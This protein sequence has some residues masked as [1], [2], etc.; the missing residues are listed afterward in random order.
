MGKKKIRMNYPATPRIPPKNTE[1]EGPMV[2][3]YAVAEWCPTPDGTGPA[4]AVAVVF[5]IAGFGDVVLRLKT[6]RAVNAMIAALIH[7]RDEVFKGA[8]G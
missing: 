8:G 6:R 2:E 3:G 1:L 7:H 5:N 4:E